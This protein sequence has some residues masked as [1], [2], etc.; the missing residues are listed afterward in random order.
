MQRSIIISTAK[1]I[2][3]VEC[4][5]RYETLRKGPFVRQNTRAVLA[6]A[7]VELTTTQE[8]FNKRAQLPARSET[9]MGRTR[10]RSFLFAET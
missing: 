8:S 5:R 4:R 2:G 3:G 1:H 6:S 10:A 9:P 7:R